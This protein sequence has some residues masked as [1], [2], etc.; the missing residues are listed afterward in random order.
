MSRNTRRKYRTTSWSDTALQA[1]LPS[2]LP[3]GDKRLVRV[4]VEGYEDVAFWRGIFDDFEN[5]KV[6]FEISVPPRPDL[7]KGKKVLL[8]MIPQSG[9]DMLLCV[10]SDF[11]YLFGNLTHQAQKV[12]QSPF[13]FHTYAYATENYSCYAPSLHNVC[14][15]ATK[16]DMRIFDFEEFMAR[17]SRIIYPLFLW[18]AHSASL[19]SEHL[20]TLLDFRSSVKL[21]YLEVENNGA[22]TLAWLERQVKHRLQSLESLRPKWKDGVLADFADNL[23]SHGVREDNVYLFMHGHTLMDNVVLVMLQSVCDKL[24]QLSNSRIAS[25]RQEC[26]ARNNELSNYNNCLRNIRD[27][28]LDNENYKECFLYRRLQADIEGFLMNYEN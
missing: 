3:L 20:F 7:A 18:Y 19:D 23:W 14:V 10:D 5:E 17:Y 21:N 15:R 8:S 11:D 27:I 16:N 26:I 4:F 2:R 25:S 1:G 22:G 13:M 9:P 24:R 28:L 12:N 6:T